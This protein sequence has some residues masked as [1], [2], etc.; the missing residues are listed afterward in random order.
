M[1]TPGPTAHIYFS[2]RLRLH[3]VDW[4]NDA[5]SPLLLIHG[6]RDHCRNWDWLA[7]ALRD[8][9]HIV[10]PDLRGHGDSRWMVGGSY[11]TID[12]VYDIAQLVSQASLAPVTIIGHSL[13]ATIALLY[14]GIYPASVRR[15]VAIEGLGSP[16]LAPAQ[17]ER[18]PHVRMRE[19]MDELRRLSARMP[20]RY[21]TLEDALQRM[22]EENRHLTPAQARHLT[23]HGSN[24]NEDGSYSWKFDNY[25]RAFPP[26]GLPEDDTQALY[27]RVECPVLLVAGSESWN[28]DPAQEARVSRLANATHAVIERAGHWVHHDRLEAFLDVVRPFL[29]A[30]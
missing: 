15:V 20:R 2:Q 9:Y 23:V 8:Q 5:A 11:V 10:A 7:E 26:I 18:P 3:Y 12:Y 22:Q 13:G 1:A 4:G 30:A 17:R 14:A 19:W 16:E 27:A 6:G 25:V 21:P 29:S 28:V 24:R